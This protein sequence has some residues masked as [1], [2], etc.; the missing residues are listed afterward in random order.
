MT[1]WMPLK[2]IG[3]WM[4]IDRETGNVLLHNGIPMA[5]GSEDSCRRFIQAAF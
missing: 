3:C 5:F 2:G 1:T 4:I